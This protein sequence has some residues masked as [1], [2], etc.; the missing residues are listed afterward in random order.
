MIF[1]LSYKKVAEGLLSKMGKKITEPLP[2]SSA[3]RLIGRG[4]F[5]LRILASD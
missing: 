5:A 2:A 1:N 4:H 3:G